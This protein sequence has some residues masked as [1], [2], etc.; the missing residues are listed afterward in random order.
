MNKR[1][2][3]YLNSKEESNYTFLDKILSFYAKEKF[4]NLL[5]NNDV[6]EIE[7]FPSIKKSGNS[8]QI[9]F[10]YYNLS[11]ILEFNEEWYEYCKYKLCC[12][13]EEMESSIIRVQYNDDFAIEIFI[14]EFI[15]SLNDDS[16]LIKSKNTNAKVKNK[17]KIY[18]IISIISLCIP[19]LVIGILAIY[20]LVTDKAI[21]LNLWFSL[22]IIIP[23]IIWS[24]FDVKSKR[25][26]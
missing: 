12:S 24:I 23:L 5:S 7:F 13:V 6:T 3:H 14:E 22:I 10:N 9:Y 18:S 19:I 17:K 4:Q 26:K 15:K 2:L 21:D 25:N 8:I 11:A 1:V 16:Q 20:S